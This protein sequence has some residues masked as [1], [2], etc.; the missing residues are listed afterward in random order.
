[1]VTNSS[2]GEDNCW[3]I[4]M[5]RGQEEDKRGLFSGGS[6]SSRRDNTSLPTQTLPILRVQTQYS[7]PPGSLLC[8]TFIPASG[9]P[10]FSTAG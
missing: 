1:M 2:P 3:N 8:S 5:N 4:D 10:P 7:P 6:Q 9:Y